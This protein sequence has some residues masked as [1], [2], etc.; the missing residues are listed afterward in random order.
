MI[1]YSRRRFLTHTTL[2]GGSLCCCEIKPVTAKSNKMLVLNAKKLGA[3]GDGQIDDSDVID[4]ALLKLSSVGGELFFPSGVYRITRPLSYLIMRDVYLH[5]KNAI[6]RFD[7][8]IGGN[9]C[10]NFHGQ[11]TLLPTLKKDIISGSQLLTGNWGDSSLLLLEENNYSFSNVVLTLAKADSFSCILTAQRAFFNPADVGKSLINN[12][13]GMTFLLV[14]ILDST[15]AVVIPGNNQSK[16]PDFSKYPQWAIADLWCSSRGYYTKGEFVTFIHRQQER[17]RCRNGVYSNYRK[18]VSQISTIKSGKLQLADLSISGSSQSYGL[19][20]LNLISAK[21]ENINIDNFMVNS[22]QVEESSQVEIS[23]S[24]VRVNTGSYPSNYAACIYSS[25]DVKIIGCQFSGGT[26]ALSHG[27]TFPCRN[28]QIINSSCGGSSSWALDFHGNSQQ[29]NLNSVIAAGGAYIGAIDAQ[30]ANSVFKNS[31]KEQGALV[32]GAEREC[33]YYLLNN[34]K[35]SNG[36]GSALV[37]ANQFA[38]N[39]IGSI[40][41]NNNSISASKNGILLQA[42]PYGYSP[43]ISKFSLGVNKISAPV[44]L[45]NIDNHNKFI[46]SISGN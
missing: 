19:K 27:G 9:Y 7:G 20:L 42:Y 43:H 13:D 46:M 12:I 3:I 11:K 41:L 8:A 21:I 30:V 24:T 5:G 6:L 2:L 31:S 28:I 40:L 25:Q 1:N 35:I 44:K 22:L 32:L 39:H 18:G 17:Y 34:N 15:H 45:L 37:I 38:I 10:L 4:R 33:N 14:S 36:E 16:D 23:N 26:H 29:I